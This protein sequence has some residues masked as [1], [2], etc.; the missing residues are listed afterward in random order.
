MQSARANVKRL[1]Q[2]QAFKT[3]YAP[4]DGVITARNTDIGALIGSGSNAKELFHIAAIAP[5]AGLRQRAAGLLAGGAAG[6]GGGHRAAGAARAA[7]SRARS[8][9]RRSR[10]IRR[11]ARCSSRSTSTTRRAS[12]CRGRTREV[13]LKLPTDASHVPAA[14]E[15]ADLPR[16]RACASRSSKNGVVAL[17]PVTLGRDFGS[18]VEVLVGPHG[19]RGGGRQPAR[20]ARPTGQSVAVVPRRATDAEAAATVKIRAIAPICRSRGLAL[21]ARCCSAT[22]AAATPPP[23]TLQPLPP[24]FKEN[25]DW[26]AAQPAD[27]AVRGAWWEVFGDPQLNALEAQIDVSNETL[28][29]QQARFLAGAR[30]GRASTGRIAIR[31]SRPSPSDHDRN[32]VVGQPRERDRRASASRTSSCRSTSRTRPTS[33]DACG[34]AVDASACRARRPAPPISRRCG[35]RCT[36]SSRST[37]SSC[38]ASTPSKQILDAAVTAFERA[39]ELTRNR[40]ARRHRVA[41]RRR[42]GRD[43][44][45]DARG[46]R[47]IDLAGAARARSSTRLPRSSASTRVVFSARRRAARR[48]AARHPG[49]A[50]RRDLL[51]RRPDIA[52]AE[53]RVAAGERAARRGAARRSFRGCF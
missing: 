25:A 26:K 34:Y 39:L 49:R 37:T 11:R 46:R 30:R 10:S 16:R 42:A 17:V 21:G 43:A 33:G 7:A 44:A 23:P 50:S 35:C 2:L 32:R 5:A 28:K 22:C 19:R 41:G 4:F 47:P 40:F 53:R 45:R 52:A 18:T 29:A 36:P 48:P 14:G 9:G 13:H 12:C 31:R 3:I 38:A 51:E 15:R 8:R 27:Q 6:D 24:A 1:E 20:L